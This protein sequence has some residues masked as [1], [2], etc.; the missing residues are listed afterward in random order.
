[1]S[2]SEKQQTHDDTDLRLAAA[3]VLLGDDLAQ[4]LIEDQWNAINE[5]ADPDEEED[6]TGRFSLETAALATAVLRALTKALDGPMKDLSERRLAA[7]MELSP[8][9]LRD[10]ACG[11]TAAPDSYTR[12]KATPF[13]GNPHAGL[14]EMIEEK[15][16]KCEFRFN[17]PEIDVVCRERPDGTA[18]VSVSSVA[19][20]KHYQTDY[21]GSM[22]HGPK[23]FSDFRHNPPKWVADRLGL[24]AK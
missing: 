4:R 22:E 6:G 8:D 16:E 5:L 1:M 21:Y 2:S 20:G 12:E 23:C 11:K 15:P 17:S 14:R 13:H 9:A 19:E 24:E 18:W 10:W 7:R 3:R